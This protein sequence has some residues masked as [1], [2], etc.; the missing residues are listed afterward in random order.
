VIL[1]F[2]VEHNRELFKTNDCT[3]DGKHMA[4]FLPSVST[5]TYERP[6]HV[7]ESSD[8]YHAIVRSPR[9]KRIW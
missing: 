5:S 6:V 4:R 2:P 1:P 7:V 9:E 3:V 8:K